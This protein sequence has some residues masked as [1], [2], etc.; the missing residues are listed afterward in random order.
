M[1]LKHH[2]LDIPTISNQRLTINNTAQSIL[3]KVLIECTF[4]YLIQHN[5]YIV[6]LVDLLVK[7]CVLLVKIEALSTRHSDNFKSMFDN[8]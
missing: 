5:D 6:K 7:M 3:G 2:L 1:F 4:F 8:Q